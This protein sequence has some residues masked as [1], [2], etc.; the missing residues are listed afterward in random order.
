MPGGGEGLE[1]EGLCTPMTPLGQ[2]VS[3]KTNTKQDLVVKKVFDFSNRQ[4]LKVRQ[5]NHLRYLY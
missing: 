2:L 3:D 5:V 1:G 4:R